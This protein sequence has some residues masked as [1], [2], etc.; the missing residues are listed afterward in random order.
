MLNMHRIAIVLGI[1]CFLWFVPDSIHADDTDIFGGGVVDIPPNVLIIFDNS[2]SMGDTIQVPGWQPMGPYNPST[3][4]T[5]SYSTNLIYYQN[6]SHWS[7]FGSPQVTLSNIQGAYQTIVNACVGSSGSNS[8]NCNTAKSNATTA[9]NNLTGSTG[10]YIGK[11]STTSPYFC[12]I[13][14]S[15]GNTTISIPSTSYTIATGN[16]VNYYLANQTN[17]NA[18]Y[19]TK[20]HIAQQTICNL[21]N[22]T[23]G[24]RWGL[25]TYNSQS[26]H[27]GVLQAPCQDWSGNI[28]TLENTINSLTPNGYTPLAETLAEAGLYFAR[29]QSWSNTGSYYSSSYPSDYSTG[30]YSTVWNPSNPS[31][32]PPAIMWRCQK[33]FVIIMTDGDSTHDN[34]ICSSSYDIPNPSLFGGTCTS[35]SGSGRYQHCTTTTIPQSTYLNG[36]TIPNYPYSGTSTLDP[37]TQFYDLVS[38]PNQVGTIPQSTSENGSFYLPDV[39]KFLYETDLL[40]NVNDA[41]GGPFDNSQFPKQHIVTYTIGF[42]SDFTD[43]GH[44]NLMMAADS[45][46]G[47]GQYFD[48]SGNLSL[49]DVFQTIITNIL[50]TNSQY[51]APVVP[52][53]RADKTYANDAIY[54]GLFLPNANSPGVWMG[55]IKKFGYSETGQILDVNGNPATDTNGNILGT[56][57]SAWVNVSG[58]DG[59]VVNAGGAG[60]E[61]LTQSARNFLTFKPGSSG[62][63]LLTFNSTN[64]L[65]ADLGL[66]T[67]TQSADLINFAT[68]SGVYA[69]NSG[70][71][72]ARTWV[73]GDIVHSQPAVLY[74][75]T[76]HKNVIFAGANDGFLHCFV[77]NDQN[78]T[79]LT[80]DTVTETW[81]FIPWSIL[82]NLQYLPST[83]STYDITGDTNHDYFVD[84]SPAVYASG[85]RDYV[86]FG[87]RRGGLNITTGGELTNQY[88]ILDVT[89]YNSPTFVSYIPTNIL[90]TTSEQLGQSWSTPHYC[91]LR[92]GT[93]S[94]GNPISH[95]VLLFAGGYD[96]N[97]D[98]SNPGA[99]D[100]MGRAIFAY[101]LPS[102]TGPDSKFNFN[103]TNYTNMQYCMVDLM[104][105]DNDGD[106]CDDTVYAPSVGGQLFVF[107]GRT[108]DGNWTKRLLFSA[109]PQDGTTSTLKKFFYAPTIAQA[110]VNGS[111][112]DWVYIGS[113]DRENPEDTAVINT[114]YA[115]RNTWPLTWDDSTPIT[116]SN[117]TDLTADNLQ[118]GTLTSTQ[119]AQL[120]QTLATGNGWYIT[121]ENSGEKMVSSPLVFNGV[122]YFTTF[123]PTAST[124]SGSDCCATG[125]GSGTARLY[126]INYLNGEA[127]YA[128]FNTTGSTSGGGSGGSGSGGGSSGGSGGSGSGGGSS[129]GSGGN[130]TGPTKADRNTILGGG[131]PSQPTLVVTQQG[132]FIVVGTTQG[133]GSY[134]TNA[135]TGLIRYFWIKGTSN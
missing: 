129:G 13:T 118:N 48:A 117:L 53:S 112:C 78:T 2:G 11:I 99:G 3:T 75:A 16:Y 38:S 32:V 106:G 50:T 89:N 40:P 119:I 70:D 34:G 64:V 103:H 58:G 19:D 131:I 65:P 84:G 43:F 54:L 30:T 62:S 36:L 130:G 37:T 28:A 93:D 121:L 83:N 52:V 12:T 69:S 110:N 125:T 101:D 23:T 124:T 51:V 80:D 8:T 109:T 18:E 49:Q 72:M 39:A 88:T 92:T 77:D 31:I 20:I 102:S 105:Y 86:A 9:Y 44:S 114:F 73:L 100:S 14:T 35:C 42:G 111:V 116:D 61:L 128:G 6:G 81:A 135:S 22:A 47:R 122:T 90:G 59:M 60:A 46:H 108:N 96:T 56:A 98:L 33:N 79:T 55:N 15:H 134:N 1:L 29:Q 115:I 63:T 24:V 91:K 7:A 74:D 85:N 127:V 5:G 132:T 45:N 82:P 76:H 71:P 57:Q 67:T 123:S 41:N 17:N 107:N 66:S 4:Y 97:Q 25:M 26:A 104:S 21:I 126:A 113:G 133:T 10:E 120:E 94:H 87:L 68:A 27:G 95:D